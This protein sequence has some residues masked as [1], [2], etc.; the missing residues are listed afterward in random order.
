MK[1]ILLLATLTC[2]G[3]ASA[4]DT[5]GYVKVAE[6][7]AWTGRIDVLLED[8]Q[9]HQCPGDLKT[10]FIM[11][12]AEPHKISFLLAAFSA[13]RPVSLS[14]SCDSEGYPAIQ[15]IRVR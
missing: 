8:N 6:I 9:Q 3:L 13:G 10:R 7:K 1:K 14:Y 12:V 2:S 4:L 11:D 15:G 5:V